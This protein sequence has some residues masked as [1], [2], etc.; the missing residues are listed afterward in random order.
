MSIHPIRFYTGII[1]KYM[2]DQACNNSI[3]NVSKPIEGGNWASPR[4]FNF[5][6]K[7]ILVGGSKP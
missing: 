7:C 2:R 6:K 4:T 3:W 1:E 5:L